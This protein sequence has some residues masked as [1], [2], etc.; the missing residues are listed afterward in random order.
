MLNQFNAC[1]GELIEL[2]RN[3]VRS[4]RS[5]CV[6]ADIFPAGHLWYTIGPSAI[7]ITILAII[8]QR[9]YRLRRRKRRISSHHQFRFSEVLRRPNGILR[10]IR[11]TNQP[12]DR[13]VCKGWASQVCAEATRQSGSA[14]RVS[15]DCCS[16]SSGP[17]SQV[18]FPVTEVDCLLPFKHI[19]RCRLI[20]RRINGYH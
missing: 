18:P 7:Q 11:Q 6:I 9:T 10:Y 13:C 8:T 19:H 5:G 4:L 1:K 3:Q 17:I 16:E 20:T 12:R 14:G 15:D 2:A